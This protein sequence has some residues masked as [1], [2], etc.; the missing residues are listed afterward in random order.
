MNV[1]PNNVILSFNYAHLTYKRDF[2]LTHDNILIN[3]FVM[4]CRILGE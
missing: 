1:F 4:K 3:I 2:L